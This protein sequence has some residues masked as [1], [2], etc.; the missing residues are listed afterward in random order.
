MG[1]KDANLA[2]DLGVD[3]R[4]TSEEGSDLDDCAS[5]SAETDGALASRT[6]AGDR[7]AF[8]TLLERHYERIYRVGARVLGNDEEA[9][10]LAQDVCVGL[11][12][13]LPSYR[14]ESRFTTWL[15]RVVV[16]AARD[17]L[18]RAGAMRR[19]EQVFA[20]I[21]S[22][23][24][25]GQAERENEAIRLRQVL[26][27]LDADLRATVILV[28][29]EGLRHAEAAEVLGVSESTVSWRMHEA[30]NRLRTLLTGEG[31]LP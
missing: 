4:Q 22:M 27:A 30:R 10:D 7:D 15:Y 23:I 19:N 8:A 26:G 18:R 3:V 17:R 1:P 24:K 12:G 6:A 28:I 16:N 21:D 9:A 29:E 2:K 13:K 5:M 11:I 14:G 25:A 20:E 31:V